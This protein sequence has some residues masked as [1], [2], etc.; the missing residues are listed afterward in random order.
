MYSNR[1]WSFTN[2]SFVIH[3]SC[4]KIN[5]KVL[6]R[7]FSRKKKISYFKSNCDGLPFYSHLL[8]FQFDI[9]LPFCRVIYIGGFVFRCNPLSSGKLNYST[10]RQCRSSPSNAVFHN[11]CHATQQKKKLC[12]LS[13]CFLMLANLCHLFGDPFISCILLMRVVL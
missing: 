8:F 3:C 1:K 5:L 10:S 9:S 12:T 11:G 6:P 7:D 13:K 2:K 4:S